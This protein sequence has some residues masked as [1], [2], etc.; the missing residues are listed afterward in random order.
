MIDLREEV[1]SSLT[2]AS[3]FVLLQQPKEVA[4]CLFSDADDDGGVSIPGIW[5]EVPSDT[6]PSCIWAVNMDAHA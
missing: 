5:R 6:T 1:R 2:G 4:V 3:R